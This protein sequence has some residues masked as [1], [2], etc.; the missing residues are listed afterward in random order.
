MVA[1]LAAAAPATTPQLTP[2]TGGRP[3]GGTVTPDRLTIRNCPWHGEI[4]TAGAVPVRG[5]LAHRPSRDR[6]PIRSVMAGACVAPACPS[7]LCR[8]CADG[9]SPDTGDH[10]VPIRSGATLALMTC[11]MRCAAIGTAIAVC[12]RQGGRACAGFALEA[13]SGLLRSANRH[14]S[15]SRRMKPHPGDNSPAP[16]ALA[17]GRA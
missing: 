6:A 13:S 5:C 11:T 2:S 1:H 14:L 17:W 7:L 4:A 3:H 12:V 10:C 16:A 9:L 8:R 15:A